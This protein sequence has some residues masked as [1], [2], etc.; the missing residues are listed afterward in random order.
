M[1]NCNPKSG[2]AVDIENT[3][4]S[5]ARRETRVKGAMPSN[6][7]GGKAAKEKTTKSKGALEKDAKFTKYLKFKNAMGMELA[8]IRQRIVNDDNGYTQA[9][10]D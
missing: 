7:T 10:I 5:I 2:D 4:E 3:R 6:A 8:S 9:D 1:G